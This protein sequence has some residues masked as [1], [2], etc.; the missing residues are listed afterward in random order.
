MHSR[1][2]IAHVNGNRQP[3][4]DPLTNGAFSSPSVKSYTHL[5]VKRPDYRAAEAAKFLSNTC[6]QPASYQP[7]TQPF[8]A[9]VPFQERIGRAVRTARKFLNH[10]GPEHRFQGGQF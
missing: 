10:P 8:I 3:I 4:N 6:D 9:I 5:P 1:Q 2:V 7:F